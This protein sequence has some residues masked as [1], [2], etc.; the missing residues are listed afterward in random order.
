MALILNRVGLSQ[1]HVKIG[2]GKLDAYQ[3]FARWERIVKNISDQCANTASCLTI[4]YEKLVLQP[5]K[6]M[7]RV[8][9]F[10]HLPWDDSVLNHHNLIRNR[11][12]LS[13][14]EP[15][16]SQVIYPIHM[17]ALYTWASNDSVLS[18]EFIRNIH[19]TSAVLK[20]LGYAQANIPPNYGAPESSVL[21]RTKHMYNDEN[22]RKIFGRSNRL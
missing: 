4:H 6:T 11:T 7:S 5:K 20:S 8:L 1:R 9:E 18:Q 10:L 3:T 21:E 15:S 22:F 13:R 2:K 19:K 16:T 17:E 12:I 14:M